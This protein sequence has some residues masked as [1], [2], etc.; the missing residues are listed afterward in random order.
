MKPED[1]LTLYERFE[2]VFA[3]QSNKEKKKML[4]CFVRRIEFDPR[5]DSLTVYLFTEPAASTAVWFS[6]GARDGARYVCHNASRQRLLQQEP[7]LAAGH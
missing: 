6:C 4:R 3:T 7:G 1:V 5:E 2:Q